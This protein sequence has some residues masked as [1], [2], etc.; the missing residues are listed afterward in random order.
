[1][2]S[3]MVQTFFINFIYIVLFLT[4]RPKMPPSLVVLQQF[5]ISVPHDLSKNISHKIL[6]GSMSYT[7]LVQLKRA[8]YSLLERYVGK[9]CPPPLSFKLLCN[10]RA[11][12][13]SFSAIIAPRLHPESSL[14]P[15]CP[16]LYRDSIF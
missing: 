11:T 13:L 8:D 3:D 10:S 2:V 15:K 9:V 14:L 1:M 12:F 6:G 4:I 5:S 7:G 16:A